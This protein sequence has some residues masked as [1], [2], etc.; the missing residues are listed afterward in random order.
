MILLYVALG[1]TLLMWSLPRVA[2][3]VSTH[4]RR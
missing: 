2:A 4:L 1:A 3:L